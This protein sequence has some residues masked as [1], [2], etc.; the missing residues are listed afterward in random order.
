MVES[1]EAGDLVFRALA[2]P[3]RRRMIERLSQRECTVGEL[4][5]P[6]DMSL[7]GASKHVGVLEQAGIL[8]REKRGRERV[9]I[10]RPGGLIAMRDWVAR[11]SAFWDARLESLD[12][13]LREDGDE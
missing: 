9:C 1:S 6:L 12:R 2:D 4:A 8:V 5:E 3:T 13:A 11:Y 10:L 7:A